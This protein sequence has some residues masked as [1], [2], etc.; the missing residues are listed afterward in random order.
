MSLEI[1]DTKTIEMPDVDVFAYSDKKIYLNHKSLGQVQ[2]VRLLKSNYLPDP[3]T[4]SIEGIGIL[5]NA[6]ILDHCSLLITTDDIIYIADLNSMEV[7]S[8]IKNLYK[9]SCI[10]DRSDYNVIY[11]QDENTDL[12]SKVNIFNDHPSSIPYHLMK[13]EGLFTTYDAHSQSLAFYEDL[14]K[15]Q[16][17]QKLSELRLRTYFHSVFDFRK[18]EAG[19][20]AHSLQQVFEQMR[21][22]FKDLMSYNL[23]NRCHFF[24]QA[25]DNDEVIEATIKRLEVLPAEKIPYL[26]P[27]A[28]FHANGRNAFTSAM[29]KN[30][31]NS[32]IIK[33]YINLMTLSDPRGLLY[34]KYVDNEL[35]QLLVNRI[36]IKSYFMSSMPLY[37]IE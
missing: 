17:H 14:D 26:F 24:T 22:N 5:E 23:I 21:S 7:M 35:A 16:E 15:R 36:D 28:G 9:G 30:V 12:I 37:N 34:Q 2:I 11:C 31:K 33:G 25:D 20:N 32:Q 27:G 3:E 8:A 29:K 10:Q 4:Q 13:R 18:N 1:K 19:N 6:L